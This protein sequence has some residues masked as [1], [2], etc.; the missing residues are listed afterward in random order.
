MEAPTLSPI[1]NGEQVLVCADHPVEGGK[2][3][4][5]N[6]KTGKLAWFFS[7]T[8]GAKQDTMQGNHFTD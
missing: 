2:L 8:N 5:I 4:S 1:I 3:Y 6:A 7:Y